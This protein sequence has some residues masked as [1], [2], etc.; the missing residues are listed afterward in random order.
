MAR[1]FSFYLSSSQFLSN[2]INTHKSGLSGSGG[3]TF[4]LTFFTGSDYATPI[5]EDTRVLVGEKLYYNGE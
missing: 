2:S 3:L 5:D 4:D 1:F